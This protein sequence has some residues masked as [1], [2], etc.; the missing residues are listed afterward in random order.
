[1]SVIFINSFVFII[2][3]QSNNL[4]IVIIIFIYLRLSFIGFII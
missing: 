4:R 1:M 2:I 3:F